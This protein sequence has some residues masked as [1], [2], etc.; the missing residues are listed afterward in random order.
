M[1]QSAVLGPQLCASPVELSNAIESSFLHLHKLLNLALAESTTQSQ[2][3]C[4]FAL[5]TL[6]AASL[7]VAL[8]CE[9]CSMTET[10][11]N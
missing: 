1:Q 6:E 9:W 5:P 2:L 4:T 10:T 8:G 7:Y 11:V 3:Y